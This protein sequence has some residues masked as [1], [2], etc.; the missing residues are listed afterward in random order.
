MAALA[1][2]SP[3]R[4]VL[5]RRLTGL[6]ERLP[7]AVA[8]AQADRDDG[9]HRTRT[10]CRR[11]RAVLAAYRPLVDRDEVEP[12]RAELQWLARALG[13]RRDVEVV[14]ERLARLL[15]EEEP[16]L[17]RGPVRRRL[18][19]HQRAARRTAGAAD[20]VLGSDRCAR[21]VDAVRRLAETPPWTDRAEKKAAKVVT[22]RLRKEL[23]RVADRVDAVPDVAPGSRAERERDDAV[24]DLRKAVKRLRYAAEVARP[25]FGADADRLTKRAKRLTTALGDRQDTVETRA[26]LRTLAAEA[27]RSGEPT[28]TWGRL[29]ARE[30]AA[31]H[32]VEADLPRLWHEVARDKTSGWVR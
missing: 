16:R 11:L 10:T 13:E 8:A 23:S 30:E 9:L 7:G 3:A 15:D 21:L 26:L 12:V 22:T 29:H 28:F 20:D 24:H 32:A 31:A 4:D 2:S 27:E 1:P 6:A 25:A 19:T 14:G 5:Q 17:V 18:A